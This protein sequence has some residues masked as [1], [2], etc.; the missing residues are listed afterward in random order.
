LLAHAD[1]APRAPLP[2][3]RLH[4][5]PLANPPW[6]RG[7][8]LKEKS[9]LKKPAPEFY[10]ADLLFGEPHAGEQE[11]LRL[12]SSGSSPTCKR[13]TPHRRLRCPPLLRMCRC[14]IRL[15]H[16]LVGAPCRA[17]DA[18][19]AGEVTSGGIEE[20]RRNRLVVDLLTS[21][22]TAWSW[23]SL[24]LPLSDHGCTLRLSSSHHGR[25]S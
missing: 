1:G 17:M 10:L 3:G 19:M 13:T 15:V 21:G 18:R 7:R 8:R 4:L 23:I 24:P 25:R 2:P 12:V 6:P 14:R 11:H 5:L 22:G 9:R 20:G 16:G